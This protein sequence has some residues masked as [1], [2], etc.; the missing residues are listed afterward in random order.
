MT[1]WQAKPN[2]FL[3]SLRGVAIVSM[4]AL[5]SF[6]SISGANSHD[7]D[8]VPCLVDVVFGDDAEG[9]STT[10]VL[11]FQHKNNSRRNIEG[12]SV[13]VMDKED[14]LIRTT[15]STCG[16]LQKGIEAGDVGAC[17][18]SLQVITGKM[19]RTLGYDAWIRMIDDQRDQLT[20]ARHCEV[21][22]VNYS[23]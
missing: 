5:L 10:Y 2:A 12:V 14:Q 9:V 17:E 11:R 16:A 22:G 7:M 3:S 8:R 15:D 20:T 19:A 23:E 6:L 4:M 13:L 18:K 1:I 21:V